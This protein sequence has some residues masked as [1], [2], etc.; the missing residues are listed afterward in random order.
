MRAGQ[1]GLRQRQ[2]TLQHGRAGVAHQVHQ[3]DQVHP[4]PQALDRKCAPEIMALW[5]GY[6]GPGR[7]A[8]Q[9][10]P[11]PRAC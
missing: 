8:P 4:V 5:L 3:R 11:Q 1:V 7:S 9:D 10:L 6:P 2:V